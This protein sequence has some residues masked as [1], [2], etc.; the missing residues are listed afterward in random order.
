MPCDDATRC[1][2]LAWRST[3]RMFTAGHSK[4]CRFDLTSPRTDKMV[5]CVVTDSR[6]KSEDRAFLPDAVAANLEFT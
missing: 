1:S 5:S 6:S 2:P 3:D 4:G